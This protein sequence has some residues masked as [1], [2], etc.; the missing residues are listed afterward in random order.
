MQITFEE[1]LEDRWSNQN[2]EETY[3]DDHQDDRF[4]NWLAELDGNEYMEYAQMWGS[5]EYQSGKID[6]LKEA[7]DIMTKD[8]EQPTPSI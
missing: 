1:F 3:N 5:I 4:D 8:Y 2:P 7:K 6:G